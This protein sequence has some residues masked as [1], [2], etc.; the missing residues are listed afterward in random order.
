M[1]SYS[2]RILDQANSWLPFRIQVQVD[3][4]TGAISVQEY[5]YNLRHS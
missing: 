1:E 2:D 5:G 3:P 4:E